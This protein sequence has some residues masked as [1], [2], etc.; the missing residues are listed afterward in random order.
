MPAARHAASAAAQ[1]T[2]LQG[3]TPVPVA[4]GWREQARTEEEPAE[5]AVASA[6]LAS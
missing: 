4:L 6:R 1:V 3:R 2:E 5:V